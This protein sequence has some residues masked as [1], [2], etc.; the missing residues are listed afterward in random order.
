MSN[1]PYVVTIADI[2]KGQSTLVTFTEI[3]GFY[4]NEIITLHVSKPYGMVEIDGRRGKIIT[5]SPLDVVIDIDSS[6]FSPFII[7]ID[8]SRTTPPCATPS[9]SG[10]DT[11]TYS[12]EMILTDAFDNRPPT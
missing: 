2:T 9:S 10:V 6:D 11:S 7:P 8:I 1:Q 12:P 5:K 4:I 3:H